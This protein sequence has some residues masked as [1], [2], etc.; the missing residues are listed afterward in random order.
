[1]VTVEGDS[2]PDEGVDDVAD[3]AYFS[4]RQA[5]GIAPCLH[6][7][8]MDVCSC[9][10]AVEDVEDGI[11]LSGCENERKNSSCAHFVFLSCVVSFQGRHRAGHPPTVAVMPGVNAPVDVVAVEGDS[12]R[13]HAGQAPCR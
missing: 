6:V 8:V 13:S 7:Q 5:D 12:L 3:S 9:L 10:S 2:L 11:L 4:E 1:V